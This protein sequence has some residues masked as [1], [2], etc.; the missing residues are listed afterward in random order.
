MKKSESYRLCYPKMIMKKHVSDT[1][2]RF[3]STT[4]ATEIIHPIKAAGTGLSNINLMVCCRNM[5]SPHH[6]NYQ[7]MNNNII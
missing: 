6:T 5:P 4:K 2:P 7:D 1:I 3:N